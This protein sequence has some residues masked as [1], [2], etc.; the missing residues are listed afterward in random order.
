MCDEVCTVRTSFLLHLTRRENRMIVYKVFY[1][2]YDNKK[3]V[4]LGKLTER[5]SD[6][7]GLS[8]MQAGLKWAMATFGDQVRDKGRLF[9]VPEDVQQNT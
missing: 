1:K 9:V 5:R 4:L 2:D 7:R 3:G 8:A 6:L